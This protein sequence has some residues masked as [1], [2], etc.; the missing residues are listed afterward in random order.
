MDKPFMT[1]SKLQ[2]W[3]GMAS[4]MRN[5]SM[6]DTICVHKWVDI[7]CSSANISQQGQ[8]LKIYLVGPRDQL[9]CWFKC[10]MYSKVIYN[11]HSVLVKVSLIPPHAWCMLRPSKDTR[12]SP[13]FSLSAF[14]EDISDPCLQSL[15]LCSWAWGEL[16]PWLWAVIQT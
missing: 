16:W 2:P 13:F 3:P 9:N 11:Y 7:T 15:H 8:S 12:A 1:F 5:M 4:S 14:P 6:L 10:F